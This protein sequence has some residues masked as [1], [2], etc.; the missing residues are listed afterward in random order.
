MEAADWLWPPVKR[1]W[2]V[3]LCYNVGTYTR[4]KKT[5]VKQRKSIKWKKYGFKKMDWDVWSELIEFKYVIFT[6]FERWISI[7]VKR[8]GRQLQIMLMECKT[9]NT[10]DGVRSKWQI[11]WTEWRCWQ[12][13]ASWRSSY[14]V[15]FKFL[16]WPL[17]ALSNHLTENNPN[18]RF[19]Y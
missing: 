9:I 17:E 18:S 2:S 10:Q 13:V 3:T 15:F 19:L 6:P 8:I 16:I 4:K 11:S 7:L 12:M 1:T 5:S 14:F